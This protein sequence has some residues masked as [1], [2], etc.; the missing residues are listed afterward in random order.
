[1][2]GGIS[3]STTYA[4]MYIS[5]CCLRVKNTSLVWQIPSWAPV[6][7]SIELSKLKI[8]INGP[9]IVLEHEH[10]QLNVSIDV[11]EY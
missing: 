8:I 4:Q 7:H 1:M 9:P 5:K 2:L 3:E 6:F 11:T 10:I